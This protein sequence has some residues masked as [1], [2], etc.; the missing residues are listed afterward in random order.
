[1]RTPRFQTHL[2]DTGT[3]DGAMGRAAFAAML[4]E[5]AAE[6][7]RVL[8]DLRMIAWPRRAGRPSAM[9]PAPLGN[10]ASPKRR[11]ANK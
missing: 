10:S 8:R 4:E 3:L 6:D 9:D 1:M 2:R 11:S 5:Q 7:T